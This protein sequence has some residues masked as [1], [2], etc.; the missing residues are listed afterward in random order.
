MK[1]IK[2]LDCEDIENMQND[3]ISYCNANDCS[4]EDIEYHIFED[5][6]TKI[7]HEIKLKEEN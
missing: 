7:S 3:I 6:S 1:V 5:G 2:I 4:Y